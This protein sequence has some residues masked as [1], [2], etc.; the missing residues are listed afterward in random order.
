MMNNPF[1]IGPR[2]YLR[3]LEV[4]DAPRVCAWLNHPEVRRHLAR[5]A[6]LARC[7]EEQF[8][9]G[10]ADRKDELILLL[11]VREGDRPI[12]TIGLHRGGGTARARILGI[13]IGEPD[14]WGQG[15]GREAIDLVL[16]HAFQT[17]DLHRVELE[18]HADHPRAIACYERVGFV[19]EGARREACFR[20]GRFGDTL[21]MGVLAREWRA[22]RA[23]G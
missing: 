6:P 8:L 13:A 9:R 1:L 12:G 14:C 4:E 22:T 15:L 16:E 17:L 11:V 3:P 20:E 21:I 2:L 7:A 5:E 19:R 10:L 18:V 23:P